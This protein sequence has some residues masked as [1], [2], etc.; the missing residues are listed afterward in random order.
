MTLQ[1]EFKALFQVFQVQFGADR[2]R[3]RDLAVCLRHSRLPGRS[4]VYV[5]RKIDYKLGACRIVQTHLS[6]CA[7]RLLQSVASSLRFGPVG[8]LVVELPQLGEE[9][10][11]ERDVFVR[12]AN[13]CVALEE[14]SC[15]RQES[16]F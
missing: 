11:C 4:K 8:T 9:D 1:L 12:L 3:F 2:G 10:V 7:A 16:R 5:I 13:V 15:A 6:C 14:V